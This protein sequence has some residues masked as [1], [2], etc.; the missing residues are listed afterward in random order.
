MSLAPNRAPSFTPDAHHDVHVR[1]DTHPNHARAVTASLTGTQLRAARDLLATFG[2]EPFDDRTMVLARID[3]AEAY[4]AERAARNLTHQGITTEITHRLRDA[5]EQ[6]GRQDHTA[7]RMAWLTL[8]ETPEI[9]ET[10]D[11]AQQIY[12]DIRHDRLVIHA[13]AQVLDDIVAVG[14]YRDTGKSVRLYGED[15]YRDIT[16]T[17]PSPPKPS[18]H[19]DATTATSC[20]PAPLP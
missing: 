12:E 10:S 19:S 3:H 7:I 9:R 17:F 14:T 13:H 2:F 4:W 1:F 11:E 16:G 8:T 5:I 18:P 20:T 6:P 15:H